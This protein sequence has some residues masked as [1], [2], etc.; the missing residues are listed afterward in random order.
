MGGN[1]HIRSCNS[2]DQSKND[3]PANTLIPIPKRFRLQHA[4][5]DDEADAEV[6]EAR[7]WECVMN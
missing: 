6:E 5:C 3:I 7:G 2:N 4:D 1:T